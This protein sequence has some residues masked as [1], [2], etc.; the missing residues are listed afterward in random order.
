MDWKQKGRQI[1]GDAQKAE[2][3]RVDAEARKRRE[4]A[5]RA[6]YESRQRKHI[7][8]LLP[9]AVN[10]ARSVAREIGATVSCETT[11][12]IGSGLKS[13]RFF[14]SRAWISIR[15]VEILIV[16]HRMDKGNYAPSTIEISA[17][18]GAPKADCPGD[19]IARGDA[20][21][22]HRWIL[23]QIQALILKR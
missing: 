11:T 15:P 20:E 4:A 22:L 23:E 6:D 18:G 17:N 1:V 9:T 21:A 2:S 16:F 12:G 10:A 5:E 13:A 3:A 7:R 8:G 14:W 19:I